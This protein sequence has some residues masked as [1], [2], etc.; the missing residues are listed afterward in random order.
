MTKKTLKQFADN[1]GPDQ[2]ICAVWSEHSLFVDIYYSI[3]WI[4]K[5]ATKAL[6]RLIW[7]CVG[8]QL[9]KALFGCS[10]SCLNTTCTRSCLWECGGGGGGGGG[11]KI[12]WNERGSKIFQNA[13]CWYLIILSELGKQFS[14]GQFFF[15]EILTFSHFMQD[16]SKETICMKQQT[17]SY[18]KNKK[19]ASNWI[20]SSANC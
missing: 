12:V 15:L 16:V 6:I 4:C 1:E 19:I 17:A 3:R 11:Y 18:G 10:T 14:R 5:R 13:I 2:R 20:C 9:H 8:L 7:A